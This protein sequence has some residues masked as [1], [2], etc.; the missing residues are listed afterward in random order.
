MA[1]NN[2]KEN[3]LLVANYPSD[4]GY[5]WWLM[6]NFWSQIAH[7]FD[8]KGA[9]CFLIYPE[10]NSVPSVISKSPIKLIEH[11]YSS[12]T[13][14]ARDK[15]KKIIQENEISNLYLTDRAYTNSN[16]AQFR[17]CGIKKIVMHDH[18]PGERTKPNLIR[19]MVKK[20]LHSLPSRICDKYIGVSKFVY[21]RFLNDVVLPKSK[22]D[23]V[24]NGI[25]PIDLE[26]PEIKDI[27]KEFNLADDAIVAVTI[28][29]AT[30]YKGIDFM[31]E[32]LNVLV[33]ED[34]IQNLYIVYIGD[35]PAIDTF[36][37]MVSKYNLEKYFIFAGR[38]NDVR[39]LLPSCDIALHASKGEAF[40]LAILEYLSAGLAT[41]IPDN[42]GNNEAVEHNQ[43]GLLYKT[44]DVPAA[45]KLL[46]NVVQDEALR[47]NLGN[48]AADSV[49]KKFSLDRANKELL[50]LLDDVFV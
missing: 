50:T 11:D 22:C 45:S 29:R 36:K 7:Y 40:S 35:G 44:G 18:Q 49:L 48:N 25:V 12:D 42:C 26:N 37:D 13:H 33:N 9:K 43:T 46:R 21:N 4:V 16:Y 39:E 2:K 38:R 30:M 27:R 24:L 34:K 47:K 1:A 15:L 14:E 10:I 23:Y 3:I 19:Y 5:A 8:A 41:I 31:I 17:K 28:A 20:I 32:C 6:E